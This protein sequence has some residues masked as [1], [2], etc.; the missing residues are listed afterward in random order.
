MEVTPKDSAAGQIEL[1][2]CRNSHK[3]ASSPSMCDLAAEI[4]VARPAIPI[5]I[6][7]TSNRGE[8][9]SGRYTKHL[10]VRAKLA[11]ERHGLRREVLHDNPGNVYVVVVGLDTLAVFMARGLSIVGILDLE[12]FEHPQMLKGRMFG[13]NVLVSIL[14][15]V[16]PSTQS[17]ILTK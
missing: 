9:Y 1:N 10:D 17:I 16:S 11:H 4:E 14:V 6:F 12:N 8:C 2:P 15:S 7:H 5:L 13:D 3:L